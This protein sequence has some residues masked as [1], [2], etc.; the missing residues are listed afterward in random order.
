MRT[1]IMYREEKEI[2][3][4]VLYACCIELEKICVNNDKITIMIMLPTPL[5]Y[6]N[7]NSL[8]IEQM[9]KKLNLYERQVFNKSLKIKKVL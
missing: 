4:G 9:N 2:F 5:S 3:R 8:E 6:F 1:Y 7:L